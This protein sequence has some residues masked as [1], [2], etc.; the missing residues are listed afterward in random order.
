MPVRDRAVKH[1]NAPDPLTLA[2]RPVIALLRV[3]EGA[4]NER[5]RVLRD[6]L[7]P[8]GEKVRRVGVIAERLVGE[9]KELLKVGRDGG[10][11]RKVRL[12]ELT[13]LTGEEDGE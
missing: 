9:L 6:S 12:S 7:T 3:V 4:E 5:A 8:P 1:D 2:W 13:D 11:Y 10:Y